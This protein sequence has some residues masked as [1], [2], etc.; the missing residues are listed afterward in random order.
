MLVRPVC[1]AI[2]SLFSIRNNWIIFCHGYSDFVGDWAS[3]IISLN[4]FLENCCMRTAYCI[5][6]QEKSEDELQEEV[7]A[8]VDHVTMSSIPA[9]THTLK[10]YATG[11]HVCLSNCSNTAHNP[12]NEASADTL[13]TA[14]G[15]YYASTVNFV[16]SHLIST[17]DLSRS[18]PHT[19]AHLLDSSPLN[20]RLISAILRENFPNWFTNPINLWRSVTDWG[21]SILEIAD[22]FSGSECIPSWSIT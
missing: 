19:H 12:K 22:V 15:L 3:T 8:Y 13:V 2:V 6:Y 4:T 11:F 21:C 1:L 10:A 7:E 17:N 9:T 14:W 20:G 5:Q 16:S 18:G